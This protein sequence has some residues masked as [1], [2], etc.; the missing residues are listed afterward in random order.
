M[1][2]PVLLLY[3][4]KARGDA[5]GGSDV[6]LLLALDGEDLAAPTNTHG[7]SLHRYPKGWLEQSARSGTLFSYHV[8]FEGIALEDQGDFLGRLRSLF[9]TKASY[10]EELVLGALV[11]KL[12]LQKD[13]GPNFAARQRFFWALRTVL[14]AASTRAG[15]PRFAA[16]TLERLV[17]VPGVAALIDTREVAP[18]EN[19]QRIGLRVLATFALSALGDLSGQALRDHLMAKGGIARDSVRVLEEDEAI[20]DIGLAIYL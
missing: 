10:Q 4:S 8:A 16:D 2:G 17:G 1:T 13:W 6:D 19:C 9:T 3:G 18:F 20:A 15:P 12:L 7:V 5:H 14:I 11:M